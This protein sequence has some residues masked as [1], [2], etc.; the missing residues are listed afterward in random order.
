MSR[1]PGQGDPIRRASQSE[2]SMHTTPAAT[3]ASTPPASRPNTQ[4]APPWTAK[5]FFEVLGAL[6]RLRVI[7]ICG[8]SV[9]E[10][11]CH[12]GPFAIEE[13]SMNMVTDAFHWHVAL[14][15]FGHLRS[16]DATHGRSGRNV[17]FFELRERADAT[18]FLRIYVY[19]AAGAPFDPEIAETF[20][21]AHAEL[22][23]GVL[24]AR[25]DA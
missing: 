5:R 1:L 2:A 12:A 3:G 20:A 15:R 17:L 4:I 9:F 24:I 10:T 22:S 6:G 21:R 23:E 16:H 13:G 8:P 11:L 19:R 18:P 25:G 14:A 7:S